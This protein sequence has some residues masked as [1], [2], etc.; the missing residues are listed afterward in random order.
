MWTVDFQLFRVSTSKSYTARG[1]I[2]AGSGR[3]WQ[4]QR[5]RSGYPEDVWWKWSGVLSKHRHDCPSPSDTASDTIGDGVS[6]VW[7]VIGG[8]L[9]IGFCLARPARLLEEDTTRTSP[10]P[11]SSSHSRMLYSNDISHKKAFGSAC[12]T[13]NSPQGCRV[14]SMPAPCGTRVKADDTQAKQVDTPTR[15]QKHA[16]RHACLFITYNNS[17]T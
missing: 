16:C 11:T 17:V 1:E 15:W 3:Q 10:P 5:R 2:G 4:W 8:I 13:T 12:T 7:H 9:S 14:R 6:S